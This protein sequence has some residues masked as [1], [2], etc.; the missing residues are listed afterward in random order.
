M[1]LLDLRR[2]PALVCIVLES[3][4]NRRGPVSTSGGKEMARGMSKEDTLAVLKGE[5]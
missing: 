1:M 2:L 5:R 3:V 4:A